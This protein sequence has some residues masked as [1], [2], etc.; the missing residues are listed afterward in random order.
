[1]A[2]EG[3]GTVFRVLLVDDEE[4]MLVTMRC[5]I[6]WQKYGFTN[7]TAVSD[8]QKALRL[9]QEEHF[10][11]AMVDIRMPG[12]NGLEMIEAAQKYGVST[13]FVIVSGYAD[14]SYARQAIGLHVLDYCLK[15]IDAAQ[16]DCMLEKLYRH[17][18]SKHLESD[19]ACANRLLAD[20][21]ACAQLLQRSNASGEM[22]QVMHVAAPEISRVLP[23][24]GAEALYVCF[25]RPDELLMIWQNE[26]QASAFLVWFTSR[27]ADTGRIITANC[28]AYAAEFQLA[29]RCLRTQ[30]CSRKERTGVIHCAA[31]NAETAEYF[32][33]IITY[34]EKN[35]REKLT[36][37]D[38]SRRFGINYTYLSQLFRK[39]AG[40]SFTEYLTSIR[41]KHACR[42]L[43]ETE[44][45]IVS[46]AEMVGFSDYHYFCNVFRQSLSMAPRQ[47]RL[48]S[49]K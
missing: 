46:I 38:I 35:Y 15:P 31:V 17:A 39:C 13:G 41:L 3:G 27:Y 25:L 36:L 11:A 44:I 26:P 5:A 42:L 45:K 18:V 16:T 48:V 47:Y 33:T 23:E 21:T 10:D 40:T 22:L 8:P 43:A 32:E 6:A 49:R 14:F 7:I 24:S 28:A 20:S 37:Q 2:E 19:P 1:M 12:M 34:M 4:L 9:L 30:C 29:L